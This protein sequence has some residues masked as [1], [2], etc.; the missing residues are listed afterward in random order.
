MYQLLVESL[1]GLRLEGARLHLRPVL[2]ADWPGFSLDYRFGDSLY[3]IHV[4]QSPQA[5]NNQSVSL[6]GVLQPTAEV[7]LL[8]DGQPHRIDIRC[9]ATPNIAVGQ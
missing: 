4:Q 6:D 8:D 9:A 1:L 7:L 3:Q 2:P 5:D